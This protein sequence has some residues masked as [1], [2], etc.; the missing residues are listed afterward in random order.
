MGNQIIGLKMPTGES[1]D[2]CNSCLLGYNNKERIPKILKCYHTYCKSCLELYMFQDGVITCLACGMT[3]PAKSVSSLPDNPYLIPDTETHRGRTLSANG[4]EVYYSDSDDDS[5]GLS[6]PVQNG[7]SGN[8]SGGASGAHVEGV[9]DMVINTQRT[10][11]HK[12]NS[13]LESNFNKVQTCKIKRAAKDKI[14]REAIAASDRL[15]LKLEDEFKDNQKI[16]ANLVGSETKINGLRSKLSKVDPMDNK[17][18]KLIYDEAVNIKKSLTPELN[19]ARTQELEQSIRN[20]TVRINFEKSK[21]DELLTNLRAENDTI[22]IKMAS[23]LESDTAMIYLTTFMLGNIFSE[24]IACHNVNYKELI[25]KA[26]IEEGLDAPQPLDDV[27]EYI[28]YINQ[29]YKSM[30]LTEN[31]AAEKSPVHSQG[32]SGQSG[33]SSPDEWKVVGPK[34]SKKAPSFSDMAKKPS[35]PGPAPVVKRV[36]FPE[37]TIAQTN[38]PHCYFKIKVDNETPFRVLFELR[39]DMAPKM[40]KNFIELC[41]GLDDGRG[42]QG[43]K[44]FRA[45]AND[46][47]LGGDFENDDGTGGRSAFDEKYFLAE[48]CPLKDQKGAIRMKGLE[49]TI[50]G[51]CRVGS[52]FMIWVGDLEYKEYRFTLVFG[53]VVEGLEKLLEVSRIKAV[54]K[55]P[56]SWVLRQ[57]VNV[58]ESGVL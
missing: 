3:T 54:Q 42:Y 40:V 22:F 49:R 36:P 21:T 6:R 58:I 23:S 13:I 5:P 41:K 30:K 56:T 38:R 29:H 18:I 33:A 14:L 28:D 57:T 9:R 39:P 10:N 48:Q 53:R 8:G 17:S 35:N 25:E 43:S 34:E 50:D 20:S 47:I 12:I 37:K 26:F 55:S 19:S 45:K 1:V 27:G 4:E 52:Q 32:R 15:K 11:L 24:K 7:S 44:I 31:P 46:H 51:R 16:T 2:S